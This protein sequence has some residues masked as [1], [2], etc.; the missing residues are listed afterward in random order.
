MEI[1]L[2]M[3]KDVDTHLVSAPDLRA[4]L[5]DAGQ[6]E[7]VIMNLAINARDAM[8]N[9]GKLTLETANVSIN[10]DSAGLYPDLKPGKYVMLAITDT[11]AGM[12]DEVKARLFEPF[13]STKDVGRG[14]GL[15]LSTCYGIIKQSGGH[16]TAR[17]ELGR[18]TSF[19]IYLPELEHQ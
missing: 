11:G 3:G 16:I 8:P 1:H 7:L 4:V 12:S 14:S 5:A 6:I 13:L 15:G 18:G 19:K 2:L 17:S 9:G 10:Q